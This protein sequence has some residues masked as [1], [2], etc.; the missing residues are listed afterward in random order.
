MM[1]E[2]ILRVKKT[3]EMD[4]SRV[5]ALRK[6]RAIAVVL[7][8]N[9]SSNTLESLTTILA[10][11]SLQ[12]TPRILHLQSIKTMSLDMFYSARDSELQVSLQLKICAL[13]C[14]NP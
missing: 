5:P 1:A 8:L 3:A 10:S 14:E 12:S 4:L 7:L 9:G 6:L 2:H 11:N 13:E